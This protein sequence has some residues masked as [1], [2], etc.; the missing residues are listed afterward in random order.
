MVMKLVFQIAQ[1]RK[2]N[3]STVSRLFSFASPIGEVHYPISAHKPH[4]HPVNTT[5]FFCLSFDASV[6]RIGADGK[7]PPRRRAVRPAIFSQG[8]RRAEF[9][10]FRSVGKLLLSFVLILQICPLLST[11]SA[12][13]ASD[14]KW[15]AQWIGPEVSLAL[16]F[17]NASWVR[18]QEPGPDI[19]KQA[20]AGTRSFRRN[21]QLDGPAPVARAFAMFAATNR[22]KLFVNSKRCGDINDVGHPDAVDITAALRPGVNHVEV[23]AGSDSAKGATEATGLIG[24]LRIEREDGTVQQIA[25]DAN[26]EWSG[27][28]ASSDW[29]S[30]SVSGS[31]GK[32]PWPGDATSAATEQN[33]WTCFRKSFSLTSVP[34]SA[35]ARIAV[36]SKYWLWVNGVLVVREGGLKR[37]PT[38][39]DTYF[40]L[41]E[42]APFLRKG[43]NTIAAL[44]WYWGKDGYSHKNS[45]QP[46]F[47][48]ELEAG[49]TTILSN[50]TWKML[51]HPAFGN[52]AKKTGYRIEESSV[53]FDARL[54]L[55]DWTDATFDDRKWPDAKEMGMPP[56][57][58]WNRLWPREIPQWKDFGLNVIADFIGIRIYL[59]LSGLVPP[60]ER[61]N[62]TDWIKWE[63]RCHAFVMRF[64]LVPVLAGRL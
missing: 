47:L 24:R 15:Q 44:A 62:S 64:S 33:L 54:D 57:A 53:H 9:R 63:A 13:T 41:V 20:L 16:D 38:P 56:A 11:A 26:W 48:F 45:G 22:F 28:P 7:T 18:A 31:P 50:A 4:R 37:G 1:S 30:V 60:A 8:R 52:A 10:Y 46:G 32:S 21:V 12:E 23:Q 61:R 25:T 43:S 39:R 34:Q 29:K 58:P 17:A 5:R 55:P 51:R 27:N 36:D 59:I 42:L 6:F 35:S 2:L 19:A 14:R 40:D 3:Q 49:T